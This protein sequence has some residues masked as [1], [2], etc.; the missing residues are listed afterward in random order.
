M[1]CRNKFG[2]DLT[3]QGIRRVKGW[4]I[5]CHMMQGFEIMTEG[6]VRG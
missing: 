3:I 6:G 4:D 5:F 2:A 1:G